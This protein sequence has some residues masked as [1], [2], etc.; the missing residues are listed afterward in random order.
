MKATQILRQDHR[1]ILRAV[2]V[3]EQMAAEVKRGGVIED[4][5]LKDILRFLQ[6]YADR[7][8]QEKEEECFFPALLR[9]PGQKHYP[10]LRAMIFEHSRERSLA[11]GLEEA[12]AAKQCGEFTYCADRLVEILRAHIAE[13][14]QVLLPLADKILSELEDRQVAADMANYEGAWQKRTLPGLLKVLDELE[15]KYAP[16]SNERTRARAAIS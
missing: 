4:H 12:I 14:D 5:D 3:L 15:S 2:T 8:H 7:H 1:H 6:E 10:K 9:D 11:E 13:E 16:E